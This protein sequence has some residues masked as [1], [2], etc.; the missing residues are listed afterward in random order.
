MHNFNFAGY[1]L[2]EFGGRLNECPKQEIAQRDFEFVSVP[3]R[4]GDLIRDNGRYKN[5]EF[6]RSIS[7]MPFITGRTASE[8]SKS[9]IDWLAHFSSYQVY[10]ETY[11]PGYFTRA[12]ITNF[13]T[14]KR[15]LPTLLTSTLKFQRI[16]Y[17]YSESGQQPREITA[18]E[19]VSLINPEKSEAF[20]TIKIERI[21]TSVGVCWFDYKGVSYQIT[22]P[23]SAQYLIYDSDAKENWLYAADGSR[24]FYNSLIF[25]ALGTGESTI[26][27][28]KVQNAKMT[29]T[30]NWRRL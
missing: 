1:W 21:N 13:D 3:G 14:V 2:S 19:T 30:P 5:V 7:F 12:V 26:T 4:D 10:R 16:P 15:E 8:L 9:I 24:S 27:V 6:E 23:T 22:V 29:I 11:N 17:W 18:A 20:M 25:P 28:T